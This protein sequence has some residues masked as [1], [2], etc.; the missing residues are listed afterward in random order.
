MINETKDSQN[1]G[2]NLNEGGRL[3]PRGLTAS[4]WGCYGGE[5]KRCSQRYLGSL[6]SEQKM[7]LDPT[8]PT[9]KNVKCEKH[10]MLKVSFFGVSLL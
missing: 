8:S 3:G 2:L 10:K 6:E 9:T 1:K 7:A 4:T 5:S